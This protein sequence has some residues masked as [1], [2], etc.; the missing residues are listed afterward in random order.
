MAAAKQA[1]KKTPAA[2]SAYLEYIKNKEVE[3]VDITAPSGFV[4]KFRKPGIFGTLFGIGN[5]PQTATAGAVDEWVQQGVL[6]IGDGAGEISEDVAKQLNMGM[7]IVDRVIHLS[8]TPKLVSGPAKNDNELSTD[9]VDEADL[10]FLFKWVAAGGEMG[11]M[12][13][14]FPK[15]TKT[16]ALASASR[17]KQRN[18]AEPT[19]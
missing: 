8:H 1:E 10:T 9:D 17:A 14:N 6:K 13:S 2:G 12:L 4:F 16:N 15:G 19:S 7:A 18:K 5:L 3:L 11:A